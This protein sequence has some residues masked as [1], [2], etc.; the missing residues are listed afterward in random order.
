MRTFLL[1]A[2]LMFS[3]HAWAGAL[4]ITAPASTQAFAAVM[5]AAQKVY[6]PLPT[7]AML[8]A[9]IG[10]DDDVSVTRVAGKKA[11][12]VRHVVVDC[13]CSAPEPRLVVSDESRGYLK[14]LEA[15]LDAALAH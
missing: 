7:L 4:D 14:D 10:E 3:A 13:K 11:K 5:P 2:A 9:S 8:P 15:R 1:A 12:K 6:P